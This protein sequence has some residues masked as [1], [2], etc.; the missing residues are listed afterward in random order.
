[1]SSIGKPPRFVVAVLRPL[2]PWE[3]GRART[4]GTSQLLSNLARLG[5]SRRQH[6]RKLTTKLPP[7]F[8]LRR[9]TRE[10]VDDA[11]QTALLQ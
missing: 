2:A 10:F 7:N 9:G 1:M 3:I 4:I 5:M 8:W 6:N 11:R